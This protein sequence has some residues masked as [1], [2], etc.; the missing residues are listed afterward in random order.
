MLLKGVRP[1][2]RFSLRELMLVTLVVAVSVGWAIDHWRPSNIYRKMELENNVMKA[3]WKFLGYQVKEAWPG[4]V[5][6]RN[7]GRRE[8]SNTELSAG[9]PLILGGISG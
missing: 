4:A 6:R 5:I 1:M 9:E 7:S 2:F 8:R 3:G